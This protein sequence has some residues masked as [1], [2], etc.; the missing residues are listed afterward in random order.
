MSNNFT[1]LQIRG[2]QNGFIVKE[3]TTLSQEYV[4]NRF[5]DM[6]EFIKNH[7]GEDEM[8]QWIA[9]VLDGEKT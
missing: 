3:M 6:V 8:E 9:H 2:V 7:V 1:A 5:V 4:F